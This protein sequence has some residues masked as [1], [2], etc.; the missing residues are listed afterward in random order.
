[1]LLI[2]RNTSYWCTHNTIRWFVFSHASTEGV[3]AQVLRLLL[4]FA[5]LRQIMRVNLQLNSTFLLTHIWRRI[6]LRR[7]GT[8]VAYSQ[9]CLLDIKRS[10]HLVMF[11]K[12]WLVTLSIRHCL[13]SILSVSVSNEECDLFFNTILA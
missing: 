6:Q 9:F 12:K 8:S 13:A 3:G 1:M 2:I 7:T 5:S 11:Q 10:Y 4:Y